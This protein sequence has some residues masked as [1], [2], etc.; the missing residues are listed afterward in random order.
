MRSLFGSVLGFLLEDE[1]KMKKRMILVQ[2]FSNF[3]LRRTFLWM[4]VELIAVSVLKVRALI[5]DVGRKMVS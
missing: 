2:N 4:V 3:S 1:R 5:C